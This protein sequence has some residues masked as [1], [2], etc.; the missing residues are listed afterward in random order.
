MTTT[1]ERVEARQDAAT[2]RT[3]SILW[4]GAVAV[5]LFAL[6]IY[7][8]FS[9]VLGNAGFPAEL[10]LAIGFYYCW[11]WHN[12]LAAKAQVKERAAERA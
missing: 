11:A 7:I 5:L 2:A 6:I 4:P 1:A 9:L 3:R 12:R 8:Q 10:V